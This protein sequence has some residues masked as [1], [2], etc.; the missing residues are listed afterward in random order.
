MIIPMCHRV[1]PAK[2]GNH[3]DMYAETMSVLIWIPAFAG[4]TVGCTG[5]TVG[6]TGMTAFVHN[7]PICNEGVLEPDYEFY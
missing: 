6:C 7:I 2:A 4:M 3:P 1:I 5:M